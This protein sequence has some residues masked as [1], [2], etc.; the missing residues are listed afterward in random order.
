M[1]DSKSAI[2]HRFVR[3]LTPSEVKQFRYFCGFFPGEKAYLQLFDLLRGMKRYEEEKVQNRFAGTKTLKNLPQ[4]KDF[5]YNQIVKALASYY[6]EA[7]KELNLYLRLIAVER[8]REHFSQALRLIRKAI[9]IAEKQEAFADLIKLLNIERSIIL[10]NPGISDLEARLDDNMVALQ[11]AESLQHNL[12]GYLEL[13]NEVVK[14]ERIRY[15]QHGQRDEKRIANLAN[16]PL[17]VDE[18]APQSTRALISK[19]HIQY[20]IHR[21]K[22][23]V[24]LAIQALEAIISTYESNHYL[25][26]EAPRKYLN[27]HTRLCAFLVLA[28]RWDEVPPLLSKLELSARKIKISPSIAFE[29]IALAKLGYGF[30]EEDSAYL[31]ELMLY[32]ANGLQRHALKDEVIHLMHWYMVR[33]LVRRERWPDANRWINA[34]L[35]LPSTSVR[36]DLQVSVRMLQLVVDFANHDWDGLDYHAAAALRF[37]KRQDEDFPYERAVFEFFRGVA[38]SSSEEDF[39]ARINAFLDE[40]PMRFG[41]QA[42]L[43]ALHYF[44]LPGWLRE[45]LDA[46]FRF[47]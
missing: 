11:K 1:P 10:D 17:M 16:H 31:H 24:E 3:E 22:G 38:R 35:N 44:D 37:L 13:E 34:Q 4:V 26:N 2:L 47:P 27:A 15:L 30:R 21:A 9:P 29:K 40:M 46:G 20:E 36:K 5:L 43:Y 28:G 12:T 8:A 19:L 39:L 25:L 23:G 7:D 14:R 18:N 32:V 42:D 45:Q 6:N 41:S 33:I